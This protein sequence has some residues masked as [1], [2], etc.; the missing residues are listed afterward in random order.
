MII[1]IIIV[2]CV[3][4]TGMAREE[5][6]LLAARS[7]AGTA[8]NNNCRIFINMF[9]FR[10]F[11]SST[12]PQPL[13]KPHSFWQQLSNTEVSQLNIDNV[14]TAVKYHPELL[15]PKDSQER[16]MILSILQSIKKHLVK[17]SRDAAIDQQAAY[18]TG[19]LDDLMMSMDRNIGR[20]Q[21]GSASPAVMKDLGSF[22]ISTAT[23]PYLPRQPSSV[24]EESVNRII[25]SMN[26][27]N[28]RNQRQLVEHILLESV[29]SF[30][31]INASSSQAM[32]KRSTRTANSVLTSETAR[33]MLSNS[34]V[35]IHADYKFQTVPDPAR[36]DI[37]DNLVVSY[38]T[39]PHFSF[40]SSFGGYTSNGRTIRSNID[41]GEYGR[42]A[43]CCVFM[44]DNLSAVNYKSVLADLMEPLSNL[45]AH[46]PYAQQGS[47]NAVHRPVNVVLTDGFRWHFSRLYPNTHIRALSVTRSN[48]EVPYKF[49][50]SDFATLKYSYDAQ[51]SAMADFEADIAEFEKRASELTAVDPGYIWQEGLLN[52][53][54]NDIELIIGALEWFLYGY[55]LPTFA[56]EADRE[57]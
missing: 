32:L 13:K 8:N 43:A 24:F 10:R 28:P 20:F 51:Q 1:I 6:F 27:S 25:V 14:I 19:L 35:G 4:P 29:F 57:S 18:S 21:R 38:L 55:Q 15:R 12:S 9:G 7:L 17:S 54:G 42:R 37:A 46:Q 47:L 11:F 50:L 48:D 45:I 52:I 40:Q 23:H 31:S 44:H 49:E 30:S 5:D 3:F 53:A 39:A 22:K 36:S 56:G 16:L 2:V 33:Q 26:L 41:A 34:M